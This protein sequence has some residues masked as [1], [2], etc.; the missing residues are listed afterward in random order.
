MTDAKLLIGASEEFIDWL[1]SLSDEELLER[2]GITGLKAFDELTEDEQIN[3]RE[4]YGAK[5]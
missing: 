1:F 4:V 5:G 3:W 2:F